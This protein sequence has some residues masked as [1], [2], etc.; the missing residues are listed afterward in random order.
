[1]DQSPLNKKK[2]EDPAYVR[3]FRNKVSQKPKPNQKSVKNK[4]FT[5]QLL[6]WLN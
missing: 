2:A 6:W 1:M 4:A 5:Q 3:E